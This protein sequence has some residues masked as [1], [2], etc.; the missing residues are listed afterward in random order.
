[1]H[2]NAFFT[3]GG[4]HEV[5]Q[6]YALAV[7]SVAF[8]SDGCS[9][10]PHT[11]VGARVL[12]H[13]ALSVWRDV[14]FVD[15]DL[16]LER[17]KASI[18]AMGAPLTALDATLGAI[19]P[20]GTGVVDAFLWGD[21]CILARRLDGHVE[22]YAREVL[23]GAPDYPSYNLDPIRQATYLQKF[24]FTEG[25]PFAPLAM[26]FSRQGYDLVAIV[27]DGIRSFNHANGDSVG[28]DALTPH[29]LKGSNLNGDFLH[30]MVKNIFL[31]RHCVKEGFKHYDDFGIIAVTLQGDAL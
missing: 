27:T 21:G 22:V 1:M 2:A 17:A 19:L 24:P 18:T 16:T 20:V 14:G 28:L 30:R 23:S 10:S 13:S 26:G 3:I 6:D 4:A 11:D 5:C 31:K 25:V 8:V 7:G 12:C 29:L 15:M 9:T